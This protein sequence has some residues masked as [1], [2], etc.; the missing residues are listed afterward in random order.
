MPF[1]A[2]SKDLQLDANGATYVS[3]HSDIPN[4]SGSNELAGGSPAYARKPIS[5]AASSGGSKVSSSSPVFDVPPATVM[6]LGRWTA[7]AGTFLGFGPIN[8]GLIKGVGTATTADVITSH[9]H[10][11]SDTNRVFLQTVAGEALP[12]GLDATTVYFVRDATTDTFKLSLTSGG[13]AVDITAV[14]ELAWQK[15]VP[16]V[17]AAQGTMTVSSD[18]IDQ[19]G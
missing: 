17:F 9:G 14:G 6:F 18:T 11:L 15:V 13:A 7:I 1:T 2:A 10:G 5:Y 16:E 4:S 3:L 8:G 12:T 19:N